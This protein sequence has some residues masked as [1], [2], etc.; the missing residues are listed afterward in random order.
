MVVPAKLQQTSVIAQGV[1]T[2]DGSYAS[3]VLYYGAKLAY[4]IADTA[5]VLAGAATDILDG[6]DSISVVGP[7]TQAQDL[8]VLDGLTKHLIDVSQIDTV[9]GTVMQLIAL[10]QTPG[11]MTGLD[12]MTLQVVDN[13]AS[14]GDLLA[15]DGLS[16]GIV[17]ATFVANLFGSVAQLQAL[18]QALAQR[19]I[20]ELPNETLVVQ[21]AVLSASDLALLTGLNAHLLDLTAATSVAGGAATLIS[22]YTSTAVKGLGNEAIV[23]TDNT[24]AASVLLTLDGLNTG[25]INASSLQ[26]LVG[27]TA[28]VIAVETSAGIAGIGAVAVTLTT[29]VMPVTELLNVDALTTGAIDASAVT[30]LFGAAAEIQAAFAAA[31]VGH[32][33]GL[34]NED[35]PILDANP[36]A[37]TLMALDGLTSGI[38]SDPYLY[39]VSGSAAQIQAIHGA[40]GITGLGAEVMVLTDTALAGATLVAL[41]G[42]TSAVVNAGSVATINGTAAAA[43]AVYGAAGTQ[44]TGLGNEA[45][46]LSDTMLAATALSTLDAATSGM[47]NVSALTSVSGT[48]AQLQVTYQPGGTTGLGNETLVVSDTSVS[49]PAL[50]AIDGLST[51]MLNAASVSSVTGDQASIQALY[52]AGSAGTISGLGNETIQFSD[53]LLSTTSLKALD[54]DTTGVVNATALVLVSGLSADIQYI[55]TSAGIVGLGNESI[56]L[57]DVNIAASTVTLIDSYTSAGV[58][59][60]AA[61]WLTGTAAELIVLYA[62]NSS[63]AVTGLG[64]EIAIVGGVPNLTQ[65]QTINAQTTGLVDYGTAV[66]TTAADATSLHASGLSMA[67]HTLAYT[68]GNQAGSAWFANVAGAGLASGDT[69]TING[70]MDVIGMFIGDGLDLSAFHLAGQSAPAQF[71][72]TGSKVGD[73]EYELVRGTLAGNVFTD[74]AAGNALLVVWDGNTVAGSVT[75]VAVVL[76]GITSIAIGTELIL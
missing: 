12:G 38:V 14:A 5:A 43:L 37:T 53:Q 60:Y 74:S 39:S 72:A 15:L 62:E 11:P 4:F 55:Y 46:V 3:A 59:A 32:I 9:S 69:F 68:A 52:N 26:S 10:E 33:T 49:A 56:V 13:M 18:Y 7:A 20:I 17:R 16:D 8:L 36:S 70:A 31:A 64:N 75:Q 2:N 45:L 47:I 28:E 44:I 27:T 21:D 57:S 42:L 22:I 54:W 61:K 58:N 40:P 73:G 23:L 76:T 51:G 25:V 50:S 24:M 34:G 48:M 63:G 30:M 6:A 71:G 67:S 1:P 65:I 41:N 19:S 66:A 35:L 29:P